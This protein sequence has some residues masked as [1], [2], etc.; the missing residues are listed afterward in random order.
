M[1]KLFS[2]QLNSEQEKVF[3]QLKLFANNPNDKIFILKGYAGTGKTSLMSGLIK[4][5][6][7]KKRRVC[8]LASTGRAA[9]ILSDKTSRS[10]K[11]IHSQIY[12]FTNI[13][14]DLEELHNKR[15]KNIQDYTDMSLLFD[16][17]TIDVKES[18]KKIIYIIDESS[19]ISNRKK[20]ENTSFAK[21]GS[22]TLLSDLIKYD[23]NGRFIFIG[24]PCQLPP[25]N[26][27]NSPAL[28]INY[29]KTYITPNVKEFSLSR[30]MRQTDNNG[31][32][33]ASMK[34]RKYYENNPSI[35][36]PKLPLRHNQN[37]EL[38]DSEISF[39]NQYIDT[40]KD[41]NIE[42]ATLICQ[43]N[44]DCREMNT[45]IRKSLFSNPKNIEID[46]VLQVTQNNHRVDL[47]NGDLVQVKKIGETEYRCGLNFIDLEVQEL[48]S[49]SKYNTLL[50]EDVLCSNEINLSK[51]K[52]KDLM[53]D[54]FMRMK[55]KGIYQKSRTFKDMMKSD[56]YLNAVR[57]VYGYALSCHKSQ[58]GE[59][60]Q[61]FL[62]I[63]KGMYAMK[64]PGL[65]QWWYTAVTRAKEKL[66]TLDDWW[67]N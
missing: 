49:K 19:M 20:K 54:Y 64:R 23:Q 41:N 25:I 32:I 36:W 51:E 3:E 48:A 24:D 30:I 17:N 1:K 15:K 10:A 26:E 34:I 57:S 65:F 63:K 9:K 4:Y 45:L 35:K 62:Y 22:G 39:I 66:I 14:T 61:V 40:I 12:S 2:F 33:K 27:P 53:M 7:K 38:V 44:R 29:I 21:F 11:T 60:N 47:V 56:K 52:Q 5:L 31:I 28:D 58:G 43:T 42:E 13:D 18:N 55:E 6:S 37:V 16:L 59:W 67:I 46:D 8:L 50:I